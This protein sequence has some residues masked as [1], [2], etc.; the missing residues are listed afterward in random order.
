MRFDLKLVKDK[1]SERIWVNL[2]SLQPRSFGNILGIFDTGSS[3]TIISATDTSLLKIP[4]SSLQK[5]EYPVKG[6]GR[7]E[8]PCKICN[9]FKMAIR[10]TDNKLK[11]FEMP[12]HF[13]DISALQRL[14]EDF[15][16]R[17]YQIPT[18]IGL[19]FLKELDL[20]LNINFNKDI[21]YLE[22]NNPSSI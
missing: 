18:V 9:K 21:A 11:I 8:I 1:N 7:G 16:T 15:K 22:E 19:D 10:S 3:R 12:V 4:I 20:S 17:A 6:F 13:V 2:R 5:A 14:N